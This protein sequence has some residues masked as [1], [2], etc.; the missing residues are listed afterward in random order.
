MA[1]IVLDANAVIAFRD[2]SDLHHQ[3][4]REAFSVHGRDELVL[5]VSAYAETPVGP[6]R[7]GQPAVDRMQ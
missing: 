6:M 7:R 4:A 3:A 5:P 2:S 1:L